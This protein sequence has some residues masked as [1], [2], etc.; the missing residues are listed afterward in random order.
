MNK[1]KNI[2]LLGTSHIANQSIKQVEETIKKIKPDIIALELDR[3]RFLSLFSEQKLK[4]KDIFKIGPKIFIL[5]LIGAYT[6][7]KLGKIVGTK[8]GDEMRKAAILAKEYKLKLALIDQNIELTLKKLIKRITW[9]EKWQFIK[10][11]FNQL[12]F[13]K[14]KRKFNLNKVPSQKLITELIKETKIKYPSVYKTLIFERNKIMA[15]N[16]YKLTTTY[17]R[18]KILAIIG[19]GHEKEIIKDIKLKTT[20]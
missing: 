5:N 15:Q 4:L 14:E 17:P 1:Y 8:P 7:K 12:I 20:K 13:K 2:Y 3:K 16:L 9:K 19:A 11:I 18:K 10:D 6:E